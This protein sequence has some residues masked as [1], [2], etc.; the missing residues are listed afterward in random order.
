LSVP[1]YAVYYLEIVTSDVESSRQLYETTY[2]LSFDGPI[3]ELGNAFVAVLPD[4]SR[5]GIRAPMADHESPIVRT[6]LRVPDIRAAVD[7]VLRLGGELA[8]EPTELPGHGKIAIYLL[9]GVQQGL[10]QVP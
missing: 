6:Y 1:E 10:W 2:G 7:D 9:G 3:P 4:G 8:L 5:C